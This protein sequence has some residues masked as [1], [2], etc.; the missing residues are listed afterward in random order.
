MPAT[1]A[2]FLISDQALARFSAVADLD[3]TLRGAVLRLSHFAHL[4]S[5][6]PDYPYL[7]LKQPQQ[8]LWADHMHYDQ[9]GELLRTM[10]QGLAARQSEGRD[11]PDVIIP[12]CW[13][14]GY[15]SHVTADLVVHPVVRNIVGD[16][17]G[18]EAEHR[19]CEMLQDTYIYHK[20]RNAAEIRHSELLGILQN[21]ADPANP[22]RVHSALRTLWGQALQTQ[23]PDDYARIPP[24]I[25]EWDDW[26]QEGMT[27]AGRP[28][29][30]G[31]L[32]DPEHKFTYRL[33]SEITAGEREKFIARLPF[34]GGTSGT[35]DELFAKAVTHVT[36]RWIDLARAVSAG[37][38]GAFLASLSNCNLDTGMDNQT[39]RLAC[40]T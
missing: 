7:D 4:G 24:V 26:Y 3:R 16:Y 25:D 17:L 10:V 5:V 2:H 37:T 1:Y 32:A 34:P 23:F 40:W 6:S 11:R 31:R 30:L 29:F 28:R 33:T 8:K 15:L 18:H 9:T 39:G 35:Y 20:I 19:E 22:T 36:D 21:C 12:F 13:T 14:L 38:P 27:I